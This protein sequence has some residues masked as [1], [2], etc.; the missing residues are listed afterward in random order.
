MNEQL[1]NDAIR[2][3]EN[4]YIKRERSFTCANESMTYFRLRLGKSEREVFYNEL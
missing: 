3:L 4:S 1:I 2:E